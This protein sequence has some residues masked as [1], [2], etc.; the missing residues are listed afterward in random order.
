LTLAACR[1]RDGVGAIEAVVAAAAAIAL[2]CPH[3]SSIRGE[4]APDS[5]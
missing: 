4:A 3:M 1:A 2:V 5:Q